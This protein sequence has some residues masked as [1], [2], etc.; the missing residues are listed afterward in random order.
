MPTIVLKECTQKSLLFHKFIY[1]LYLLFGD[2]QSLHNKATSWAILS[3]FHTWNVI[4]MKKTA[5]YKLL[6]IKN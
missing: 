3:C 6:L 5:I 4:E 2:P 1:L